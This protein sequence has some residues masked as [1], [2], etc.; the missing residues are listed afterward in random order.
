M[1]AER[2]E[3]GD[4]AAMRRGELVRLRERRLAGQLLQ[5]LALL[6]P[7]QVERVEEPGDLV[8]VLVDELDAVEPV[9]DLVEDGFRRQSPAPHT[10]DLDPGRDREPGESKH[11]KRPQE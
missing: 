8:V 9:V 3:G 6:R 7:A 5:H 2:L 10:G 1:T 11:R 4:G